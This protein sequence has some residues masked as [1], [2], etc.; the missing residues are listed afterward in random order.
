M[1]YFD[2]I[3]NFCVSDLEDLI[4]YW[5]E[6]DYLYS[7]IIYRGENNHGPVGPRPLFRVSGPQIT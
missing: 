3:S 2:G 6:S 1:L 5:E 7:E 4:S